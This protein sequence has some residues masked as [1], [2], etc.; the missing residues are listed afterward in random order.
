MLVQLTW[1]QRS[2]LAKQWQAW[3]LVAPHTCCQHGAF[4]GRRT[5]VMRPCMMRKWGLFTLS[6]TEWNRFCTRLHAH[7]VALNVLPLD[8]WVTAHCNDAGM[9]PTGP[10]H[11]QVHEPTGKACEQLTWAV[12]RGR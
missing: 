1:E 5:L 8:S 6:D 3:G 7:R 4:G 10:I 11:W 9:H 12:Q 2:Q